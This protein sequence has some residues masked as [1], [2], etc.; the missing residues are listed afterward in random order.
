[1]VTKLTMPDINHRRKD[2]GSFDAACR[3]GTYQTATTSAELEK[4]QSALQT[5]VQDDNRK[6]IQLQVA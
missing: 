1:M 5:I 4:A 6:N 3:A 2:P